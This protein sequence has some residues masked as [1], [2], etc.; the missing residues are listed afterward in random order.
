[1]EHA[2][3][4][5]PDDWGLVPA[6]AFGGPT[7]RYSMDRRLTMRSFWAH[8][9]SGQV[10]QV[11]YDKARKLQAKQIKDRFPN[12]P[13]NLITDTWMGLITL[14]QNFAPG[15]GQ[16]SANVFTAVCQNGVGVTKGTISGLLAADLATGR[17][18][19][20]MADMLGL[21]QPARL[22]PRPFLD[23]GVR[24]KIKLWEHQQ[25]FEA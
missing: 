4:G 7:L 3:L 10:T 16:H 6:M 11:S 22:P 25:R 2:S 15:F 24:A 21:G 18:N 17:D 12:L 19:P 9:H 14:S 13:P 8:S 23:L 20:L 5:A 1:V